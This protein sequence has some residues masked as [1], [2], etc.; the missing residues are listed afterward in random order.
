MEITEKPTTMIV[1][2]T[3]DIDYFDTESLECLESY[4]SVLDACNVTGTFFITAKAAGEYPERVEYI[5]KHGHIVE[6]HGDIHLAFYDS[7]PVQTERMMRMKNTFSDLFDLDIEGFR[8]PFYQHN[9]N[10]YPA[11]ERAGLKYDCSK[12]RFETAF[13]G[14]PFVQKRYMFTKTYPFIKPALKCIATLYNSY[15][16]SPRKPYCITPHVVEFPT[17]G[18]SDYTLIEDPH[19]PL[20]CPED[21]EK[22]GT[23]WIDGLQSYIQ[24]GGGVMT[25]QAHPGR[26]APRYIDSLE[27]F[28]RKAQNLGATFST[29]REIW[30]KYVS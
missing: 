15:C 3:G 16:N 8:A 9:K 6:G 28:I 1:C 30:K 21:A 22:I 12:K 5:M 18:I 20:F 10:T 13:K 25:L 7:V 24:G 23:I 17:L 2:I 19:G 27:Y 29:P 26:L 14:I 11:A 4:F